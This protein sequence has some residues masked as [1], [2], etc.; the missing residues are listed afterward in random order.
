[1][2]RHVVVFTW[3]PNADADRRAATVEALRGLRQVVGGMTSLTV[4]DDAGLVDGNADTVLIADFPDVAAFSRYA[5]DPVHL[6]VIAEHVRP[7]LASRSAV[8]YQV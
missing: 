2:I 5:Q 7:V 8:Q 6:A 4:A 3:S 1:M